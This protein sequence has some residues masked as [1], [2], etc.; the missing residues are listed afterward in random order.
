VNITNK[1][2]GS[3]PAVDQTNKESESGQLKVGGRTLKVLPILAR[4]GSGAV[5]GAIT[6]G[7]IGAFVGTAVAPGLGTLA[8]AVMGAVIGA[9]VGVA[10]AF[11]TIDFPRR[12]KHVEK[13]E[14]EYKKHLETVQQAQAQASSKAPPLQEA[15]PKTE[16]EEFDGWVKN[17][18]LTWDESPELASSGIQM[19]QKTMN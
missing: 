12:L 4:L 2:D 6:G 13:L 17:L 7:A 10:V 19:R 9:L 3:L 15:Q 5:S 8:C 18:L 11:G 14:E 16:Q 1:V